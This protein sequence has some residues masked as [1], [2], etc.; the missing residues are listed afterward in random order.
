MKY[1]PDLSF[2]IDRNITKLIKDYLGNA[3]KIDAIYLGVFNT[4]KLENKKMTN[5]SGLYHHDSVGHRLKL[6]IPINEKGNID[7]PTYYLGGSNLKE[8]KSYSNSVKNGARISEEIINN[9][10]EVSAIV[11]FGGRYIFDTNGIHRGE[12]TVSNEFRAIL[13]FEFSAIE[14]LG[15]GQIGA[16]DYFLHN[17]SF[18]ILKKTD[19]LRSQLFAK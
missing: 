14:N 16:S 5:D 19:F 1:Y 6:F 3:A 15:F 9:W 7:Y 10:K 12:Y 13:Q 2:F 18:D 11:P 17:K 8:W 4:K